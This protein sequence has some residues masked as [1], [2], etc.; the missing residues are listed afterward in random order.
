MIPDMP[1]SEYRPDLIG[2]SY[3]IL[4]YY[5]ARLPELPDP[6]V[7]VELG[8]AHGRTAFFAAEEL[9]KTHRLDKVELWAIDSW[10]HDWFNQTIVKT[11]NRPELAFYVQAHARASPRCSEG[12]QA[13]RRRV[14]RHGVY[15]R[16]PQPRRHGAGAEGLVSESEAGRR[17]PVGS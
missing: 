1:D 7:F 16:R 12:R 15:R 10:G 5:R 14:R 3:D 17:N 2:W 9:H 8:V 4:P 6:A 13:L 11:L